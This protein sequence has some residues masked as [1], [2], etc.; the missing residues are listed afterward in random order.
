MEHILYSKWVGFADESRFYETNQTDVY[1]HSE[2][3]YVF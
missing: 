3:M 1:I 2:Q